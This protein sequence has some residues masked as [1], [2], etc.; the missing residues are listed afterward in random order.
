M[1]RYLS[2]ATKGYYL[3]KMGQA[4]YFSGYV[5]SVS[6]GQIELTL[7]PRRRDHTTS[8]DIEMIAITIPNVSQY[9]Q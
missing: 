6:R 3:S 2:P 4:H 7:V 1:P 9:I 5:V 8:G